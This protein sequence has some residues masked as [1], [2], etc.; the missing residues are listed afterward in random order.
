MYLQKGDGKAANAD[1][2]LGLQVKAK[3]IWFKSEK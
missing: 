2:G 3:L 1:H